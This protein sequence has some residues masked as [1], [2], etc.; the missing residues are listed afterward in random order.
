[1]DFS[2]LVQ[3]FTSFFTARKNDETKVIEESK[4]VVLHLP[5]DEELTTDEM[6]RMTLHETLECPDCGTELVDGPCGGM[7]I[8]C[9]C[10]KCDVVFNVAFLPGNEK[11]W[12]VD[13]VKGT[14]K[15][16]DN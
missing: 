9:T 1:M 15:R 3:F 12:F 7:S 5:L 10:P 13:V 16:A 8:N 4:E 6:S 2:E 11:L 14:R